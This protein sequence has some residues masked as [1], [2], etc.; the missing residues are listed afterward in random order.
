MCSVNSSFVIIVLLGPEETLLVDG[1]DFYGTTYR[2]V[3][4]Y[5]QDEQTVEENTVSYH[6][7][8]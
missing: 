4:T 1:F 2:K 7:F 5:L 8:G 3:G 6:V